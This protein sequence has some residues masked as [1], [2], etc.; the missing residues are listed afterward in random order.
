MINSIQNIIECKER[1]LNLCDMADDGKKGKLLQILMKTLPKKKLVD[2]ASALSKEYKLENTKNNDF[3]KVYK[4]I[5]MLGKYD[6][7]RILQIKNGSKKIS[8]N[9]SD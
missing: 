4:K 8:K 7:V 3:E 9:K 2:I 5:L 6:K 1:D